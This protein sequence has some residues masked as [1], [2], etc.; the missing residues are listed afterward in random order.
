M[1]STK[2]T[3]F[4]PIPD[5]TQPNST[6]VSTQPTDNCEPDHVETQFPLSVMTPTKANNDEMKA[7]TSVITITELTVL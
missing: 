2:N 6:R 7:F 4:R 1:Q 3:N 5:P